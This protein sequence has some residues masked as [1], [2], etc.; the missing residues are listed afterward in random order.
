MLSRNLWDEHIEI[1]Q[2]CLEH[3]FVRGIAT[4]QL[5]RSQFVFFVEQDTFFLEAFARAYSIAAAKA[6]D[7][8]GFRTFHRLADGVLEE[9]QLHYSY[10]RQWDI[11][12]EQISP[13]AAT[14]R[15]TDFLLATAWS[16][17]IGLTAVAMT[18]CMRLYAYLGQQLAREGIRE[19]EYCSWIQTYSSPQFEQLAQ[20]IEALADRYASLTEAV[21]ETYRYAMLCERDFFTAAWEKR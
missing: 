8:E 16:Q 15:Y 12:L 18:S 5:E 13:T 6:P 9:L 10:A 14:R 1:A 2:D 19:H 17:D 7:W 3:P 11:T 20:Q 21:R 4:G